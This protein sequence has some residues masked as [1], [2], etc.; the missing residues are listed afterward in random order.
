MICQLHFFSRVFGET[1]PAGAISRRRTVGQ[2]M[3]LYLGRAACCRVSGLCIG[4]DYET[5]ALRSVSTVTTQCLAS[6]FS[7]AR[8]C[9]VDCSPWG[10][11]TQVCSM[12]S[13][14]HARRMSEVCTV[15]GSSTLR[16]P[17]ENHMHVSAEASTWQPRV[18]VVSQLPGQV[19][20]SAL[21]SVLNMVTA[22]QSK[23]C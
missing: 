2:R 10:R 6:P 14:S 5:V 11:V 13:C 8:R 15:R 20:L 23:A 7:F 9:Q 17:S 4:Q 19:V 1:P 22:E 12:S 18:F 16:V 3:C 21:A